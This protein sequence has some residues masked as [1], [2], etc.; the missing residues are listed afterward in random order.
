[1]SKGPNGEAGALLQPEG[2]YLLWFQEKP[3]LWTIFSL[4]S[5]E[6][7]HWHQ[8]QNGRTVWPIKKNKK[9]S[10]SPS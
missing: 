10:P 8:R 7:K 9:P 4:N 2:P 1:M 3:E 6:F 5:S